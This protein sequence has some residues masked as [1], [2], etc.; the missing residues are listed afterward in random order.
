MTRLERMPRNVAAVLTFSRPPLVFFAFV[1]SLWLMFTRFPPAYLLGLTF[2]L[3]AMAFDLVDGWFAERYLPHLRLGALV[4]RMMD[5]I[6]LSIIFPVL[7][8]GMLWRYSRVDALG[9]TS[10]AKLDLLHA[11]FVLGIC[12]TVLLRDQFAHFMRSFARAAG[13]EVDSNELTRLR[14]MVASPMAVLLYAY[15]FYQPTEGWEAAYR[16]VD[17]V[18]DVPLRVWFVVE[19]AFLVINIASVTLSLRKYGAL[20]LDEICEDDELLR[21]RILSVVPN[22]LTLMNGFLGITAVVF[23]SYGRVREALFVMVGAAFL[24]RLDGLMARRL[25]LT[26]Y[27]P[28][29]RSGVSTGAL[30]DDVSD[31]ISFAIAPAVMFYLLMTDLQPGISNTLIIGASLVYGVAGLARLAYF[32]LDKHPIPGFFKGLP[33]PAAALAASAAIEIVHQQSGSGP[34]ATHLWSVVSLVTLLVASLLMNLYFVRYLHIG[35][36]LGRRPLLLRLMLL[37]TIV[38]VFTPYFGM[39]A[40]LTLCVYAMSPIV[41]SRIDPAQAELE[42]RTA[43]PQ[44]SS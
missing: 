6:V 24:D 31:G 36:L 40:L 16:W 2:L 5:R 26:E 13:Q 11:L 30:L 34:A 15:A 18:D 20:A 38:L 37:V 29:G 32:T 9:N 10:L 21:R 43:P 39:V 8:A 12:V 41:T 42:R 25:G 19:S 33:V 14:T 1:C 7:G 44:P 3:L 28:S 17:W 27:P 23:T 22:T 4:D 35:R